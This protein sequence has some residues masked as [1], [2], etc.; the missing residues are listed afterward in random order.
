LFPISPARASLLAVGH[1][2]NQS[3]HRFGVVLLTLCCA[4]GCEFGDPG[5]LGEH[6]E[7][8]PRLNVLIFS[9]DALRRDVLGVHGYGLE[10]S[11]NIDAFAQRALVFDEAFAAAPK[12]PTSFASAF[13]GRYSTR[14]FRD[15]KMQTDATLAQL[16]SD[17]GY[18]TGGFMNNPQL[19]AKRGFGAGFGDYETYA[20]VEDSKVAEAALDWLAARDDR[21]F[22]LWVHLLDPH[23]PWDRSD[24]S[25]HLYDDGYEGKYAQTARGMIRLDDPAEVRQLKRLYDG[26]V[27]R[28]DA[29]FGSFMKRFDA[30]TLASNTIVVFTSDHGEEF[31]EHGHL[32]HG[33][34]TEENVAIP[35]ILRHPDLHA[36]VRVSER[37]SNL[38]LMPTLA[39]LVGLELPPG[40]DGRNLLRYTGEGPAMLAIANTSLLEQG[41]SL[42]KGTWKV[43]ERCGRRPE[44]R[45]F[46]LAADPGEMRDLSTAQPE[47]AASLQAEMWAEVGLQGCADLSVVVTGDENTETNELPPDTVKALEA[48]GYLQREE[49]AGEEEIEGARRR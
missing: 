4:L 16:F 32:Q 13:T 23:S 31:M 3:G 44:L 6:L 46:D 30:M 15:W 33:W 8:R 14:V 11:P 9:V 38:D 2:S 27:H 22:F 43:I 34:L 39:A 29:H 24:E 5:L 25:S 49:G 10:T 37:V 40:S 48:L 7:P 41:I 12:T 21:P 26:E 45:L 1:F 19:D 28:V 20:K 17:A 47:I 36:G 42:V 18:A 35:W